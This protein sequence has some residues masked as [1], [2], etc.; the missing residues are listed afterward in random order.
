[1]GSGRRLHSVASC[2][3]LLALLSA[4]SGDEPAADDGG[5]SSVADAGAGEPGDPACREFADPVAELRSYPAMT[6]G[7][8]GGAGAD[9]NVDPQQCAMTSVPF[10][11]QAPGPDQV[12]S[13]SELEPGRMYGV[14]VSSQSDLAFYIA[15][16]CSAAP[17]PS[18]GECLLFVDS[19]TGG[20]ELGVFAGPPSGRAFVVVDH[21]Q[22]DAP[23]N[24]A[25]AVEVYPTEC[26][27]DAACGGRTPYCVGYRCVECD[28]SF[29]CPSATRPVCS[30][31][32]SCETG[33]DQCVGDG[34]AEGGDDGPAGATDV[35]PGASNITFVNGS[36]CNAPASELDFF[37]FEVATAGEA[38]TI[39]LGW[40]TD[41]DLDLAVYDANG[42]TYGL[43]LHES[44]ETIRLTYLAPGSYYLSVNQFSRRT[45]TEVVR[46]Q[47]A[48]R[49]D[50]VALCTTAADCAAEHRNQLFRGQCS[51]GACV[52]LDGRG[53]SRDG[54]R[55]D[56]RSD[57]ASGACSSFFFAADADERSLCTPQCQTDDEC[58]VLGESFVCTTYLDEN[59]CV[60]RCDRDEHCPALLSIPPFP[61]QPWYRL[62]C[63]PVTGRCMP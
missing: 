23:A 13:L 34:P 7:D 26:Q 59:I 19:S 8:L 22:A 60:A 48:V 51:A 53:S 58:A 20:S 50:G 41:T 45:S 1:M 30:N 46:Y 63:N 49:R 32:N 18:G 29:D 61:G 40:D 39:G 27:D 37:R 55:C 3:V 47:V 43:S 16:G 21:Y 25:F 33:P 17:G 42:E 28:T 6:S 5:T 2:G 38:F 15:T 12:V 62:S 31:A 54:E 52:S 10:G 56:S 14:R 9:L 57:C 11:A 44:P 24:G 36:I 35:T 4:C